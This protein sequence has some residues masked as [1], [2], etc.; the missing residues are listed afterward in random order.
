MQPL[1]LQQSARLLEEGDQ[2]SNHSVALVE[3]PLLSQFEDLS[4][5]CLGPAA[6]AGSEAG[7]SR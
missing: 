1:A 6:A 3:A 7:G 5:A 4:F 2:V